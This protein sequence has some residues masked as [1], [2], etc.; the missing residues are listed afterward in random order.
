MKVKK[1][2]ENFSIY[3][4]REE[5]YKNIGEGCEKS[6]YKIHK[7][8]AIIKSLIRRKTFSTFS[9]DLAEVS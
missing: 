1:D 9:A 4:L 3:K 5:L 7:F 8:S 2:E 6:R